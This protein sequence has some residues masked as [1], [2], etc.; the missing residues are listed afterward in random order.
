MLSLVILGFA[1][2]M[3]FSEA[4]SSMRPLVEAR[5]DRV[6]ADIR[7]LAADAGFTALVVPDGRFV[8]YQW[9]VAELADPAGFTLEYE[10]GP[11]IAEYRATEPVSAADLQS[12]VAAGQYLA[13]GQPVEP[14]LSQV[15]P[16][17]VAHQDLTV[18][19]GPAIGLEFV[20][21]LDQPA[22][23]LVTVIGDVVVRAWSF[24][25]DVTP[26]VAAAESLVPLQ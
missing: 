12:M 25:D 7:G 23:V 3:A 18:R 26:L 11:W 21:E 14:G 16:E 5:D 2:G 20:A 1:T 24:V 4:F 13:A 22:S 15:I 10:S 17:G 6:M 19:G 9:P 8:V